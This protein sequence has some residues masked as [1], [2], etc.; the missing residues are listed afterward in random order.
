MENIINKRLAW[1][2]EKNNYLNRNQCGF[3]KGR[4]TT[5]Q[6]LAIEEE[7]QM[8]FKLKHHLVAISFDIEKAY[9]CTW[10]HNILEEL[11][12]F[13]VNG[14]MISFIRNFL[15]DRKFYVNVNGTFSDIK[16]QQNGVPQG[17]VLSVT[18]F[19]LAVNRIT[20]NISK[21]V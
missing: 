11:C 16:F 8:A 17:A 13:G 6:L 7:I 9:E 14:Y 2:L 21:P 15:K 1:Y 10:K 20:N 12:K 3:R 5:D 18:L 4:S 19:L